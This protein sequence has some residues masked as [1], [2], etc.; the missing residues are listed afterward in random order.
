MRTD[1]NERATATS[2]ISTFYMEGLGGQS[3]QQSGHILRL[4]S[5]EGSLILWE[6]PRVLFK[7][8]E[9]LVALFLVLEIP[10]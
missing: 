5:A 4:C 10:T 3:L 1:L 6:I 2:R 7:M 8:H 9:S